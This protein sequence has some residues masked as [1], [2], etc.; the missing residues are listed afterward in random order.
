MTNHTGGRVHRLRDEVGYSPKWSL[1]E[2][3]AE[4]VAY[5]D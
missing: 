3:M 1:G 4:I 5:G 2:A